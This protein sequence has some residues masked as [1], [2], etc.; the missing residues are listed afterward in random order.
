[1]EELVYTKKEAE[2]ALREALNGFENAGSR[3]IENRNLQIK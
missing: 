2:K 1:M 3:L